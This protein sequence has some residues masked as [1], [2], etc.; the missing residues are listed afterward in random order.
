MSASPDTAGSAKEQR[1]PRNS[2]RDIDAKR[3]LGALLRE[4][5][6]P[7]LE[8]AKNVSMY[9]RREAL[10]DI[11]ALDALYRRILTVPGV[12][13]ELG[14][15]WGRRLAL[16]ELLREVYEPYNPTRRIVGFDTFAGIPTAGDLDG[17]HPDVAIGAFAVPDDYQRYLERLLQAHEDD[18]ALSHIRRF[19]L[20]CGNVVDTLP[21]YLRDNPETVISLAYFD[22]DLYE[23]TREC[24]IA[25]RPHLVRGSIVAFDELNHGAFPGETRAVMDVLDLPTVKIEQ[26]PYFPFPAFITV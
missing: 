14:V 17:D 8:L 2:S 11:L 10:V 24:L 7:D 22:L 13:M 21:A 4:T 19:D 12:V 15:R 25:M 16:L 9:M 1:I 18:G 20:C 23:P 5:P 6:I 26:L 3:R